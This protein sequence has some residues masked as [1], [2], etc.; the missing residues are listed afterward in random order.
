MATLNIKTQ[1]KRGGT[2]NYKED[3]AYA[4]LFINSQ[5]CISID[6]FEGY[7][8]TYKRREQEEINI[9]IFGEE[10]F[11]GTRQELHELLV[12]AKQLQ[13]TN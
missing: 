3:I 10:L 13:I 8:E 9:T 1:G 7:G 2:P 11:T 12:T 5:D 6:M 4:S